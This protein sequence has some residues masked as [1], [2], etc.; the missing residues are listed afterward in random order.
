LLVA[1]PVAIPM[2]PSILKGIVP[3]VLQGRDQWVVWRLERRKGKTTKVPHDPTTG[4]K[5]KADDPATWASFPVAL[6][7]LASGRYAGIGYEFSAEDPF[8]GVDLDDAL[9]E[10][11][12]VQPWAD[13]LLD[14]LPP[15]I[16]T[17]ISPSGRGLHVILLAKKS[18]TRCRT[19]YGG[20]AV[21]IYDQS[22]YF[23]FTAELL[24]SERWEIIE[25]QEAL[26]QLCARVFGTA[27]TSEP[28]PAPADD[29]IPASDEELLRR[30]FASQNGSRIEA[31]WNGDTSS[32]PSQSEADLA[33]CSHL[34]F[35]TGGDTRRV[36]ALF[37]R[38]GLMRPK[39]KRADYRRATLTRAAQGGTISR[40]V[41]T[42]GATN[43]GSETD[44]PSPSGESLVLDPQDE[45][46]RAN[47]HRANAPAITISR[48]PVCSRSPECSLRCS[49]PSTGGRF[50]R[51]WQLP[52]PPGLRRE[53]SMPPSFS[54]SASL[55]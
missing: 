3:E 48:L 15:T 36:D 1:E 16:Y 41:A 5:A 2:N 12:V 6:Q 40:A 45:P 13:E 35:W 38:S 44:A 31:L 20:G 17:E 25:A 21:E 37:R 10:E 7:A 4:R 51:R 50:G 46:Q 9:D 53:S 26:D 34:W 24:S 29:G 52:S 54:I 43:A 28:L 8:C 18:H 19:A 30:A 55:R 11:G 22:R 49:T 27:L 39:W 33:L 42:V 32:Y 47:T 23:T 14:L